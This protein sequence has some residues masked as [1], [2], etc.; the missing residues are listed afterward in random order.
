VGGL[1]LLSDL[2][3][4]FLS[5]LADR[6]S[7]RFVFVMTQLHRSGSGFAPRVRLIFPSPYVA[8]LRPCCSAFQGQCKFV[9]L[10]VRWRL[11]G[12]FPGSVVLSQGVYSS[13]PNA[14]Q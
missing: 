10:N 9:L 7:L 1:G 4:P 3:A 14:D 13:L 12:T 6:Q 8:V 2:P 5:L 11:S